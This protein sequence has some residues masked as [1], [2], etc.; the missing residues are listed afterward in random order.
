M[1]KFSLPKLAISGLLLALATQLY[2]MPFHHHKHHGDPREHWE[3]LAQE[4]DLSETQTE[5]FITIMSSQREKR[6]ALKES[7][8]EKAKEERKQAMMSLREDTL[9]EL[10]TLLS[11]EQLESF[12]SEMEE[13]RHKRH[14]KHEQCD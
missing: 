5:E 1:I 10:G 13:R 14:E 8:R 3:E 6:K 12:K 4:M 11:A 7:F 9:A 2:A